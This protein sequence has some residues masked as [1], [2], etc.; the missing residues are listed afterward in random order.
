MVRAGITPCGLHSVA[1]AASGRTGMAPG[2]A[3]AAPAAGRTGLPP[4]AAWAGLVEAGG[5]AAIRRSC[6]AVGP[7]TVAGFARAFR[8]LVQ[9]AV[10]CCGDCLALAPMGA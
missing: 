2:T 1:P 9:Y 3:E 7:A 8:S 5:F 10:T 6:S 4:G